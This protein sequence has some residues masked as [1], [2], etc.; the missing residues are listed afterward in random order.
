M[1]EEARAVQRRLEVAGAFELGGDHRL[2][3]GPVGQAAEEAGVQH[4]IEH[5]PALAQDAGEPGGGAHDGGNHLEQGRLLL[6]Q[7]EQLH[8]RR[9]LGEEPVEADEGEV[10]IGRLGER[11]DQH[12]LHF[13][14]K[15][16]GA[17]AAHGWVAP[18]VPAADERDDLGRAGEA[19]AGERLHGRGVVG[20]AGKDHVGA[21]AR[22]F[23]AV[24][25]QAD[26]VG[27]HAFQLGGEAGGEGCRDRQSR[28]NGQARSSL[29]GSSGS[30][31]VCSSAIICRRCSTVRRKR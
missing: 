11:L 1:A 28:R 5:A 29:S 14:E 7:R 10:G 26:V 13:G 23:R 9:H 17:R 22:Q 19:H 16:A 3:V 24:L 6:E 8:A 18:V 31:W 25:E 4:G 12:R 30:V 2:E 20:F 15:L 21:A 27:L